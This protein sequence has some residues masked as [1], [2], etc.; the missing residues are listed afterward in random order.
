[1]NDRRWGKYL[2]CELA[3]L[4][5]VTAL[6]HVI[7][8]GQQEERE[9]EQAAD[10]RRDAVRQLFVDVTRHAEEAHLARDRHAGHARCSSLHHLPID[11]VTRSNALCG[12]K[13][14][15]GHRPE[16][17]G[18]YLSLA[19]Q[20]RGAGVAHLREGAKEG[21][22]EEVEE[23]D[24]LRVGEPAGVGEHRAAPGLGVLFALALA[25]KELAAQD[26]D[27]QRNEARTVTILDVT[28]VWIDMRERERE[29]SGAGS[30]WLGE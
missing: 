4:L 29:S 9:A 15:R 24:Q 21:L 14:R 1:M 8:V 27:Q 28:R 6:G 10:V 25:R 17:V 18:A 22:E 13:E 19:G 11:R 3:D 16:S 5:A 2:K 23:E 7:R 26:R 20:G 12:E 30:E